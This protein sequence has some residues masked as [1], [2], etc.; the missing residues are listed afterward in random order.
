MRAPTSLITLVAFCVLLLTGQAASQKLVFAHYMV[1]TVTAAHAQQDIK[2]AAAMGL[3]GFALNIGDPT[4]PFVRDA[5]N[6]MFDFTRDKYPKFKLFFSL[7][8]WASGGAGKR[9]GDYDS[10]LR[11]FMGH[12]AY[13]KGANGFP[14]VSTFGDGGTTKDV[15]INWKKKWAN[16]VYLVP[17]FD[18]TQGY[19][20]AAPGWWS[21]WGEVVDGLFSWESSWPKVGD[22]NTADMNLDKTVANGARDRKKAYMIGLSMLQYKNAYGARLWRAG[23]DLLTQRM[24]NILNMNP[25]PEYVEILTWN[26]GPEG[27]YIGNLWPEQNG[28]A[29]PAAYANSRA[30]HWSIQ[31]LLASFIRAYKA[32]QGPAA[33][34]PPSL[35]P[36]RP[37][38]GAIWYKP[39]NSQTNCPGGDQYAQKPLGYDAAKD[40]VAWAVVVGTGSDVAGWKVRFYSGGKLVGGTTNL[41]AGLNSGVSQAL[42]TGSQRME[43]LNKEG[44][45]VMRAAGGRCVTNNCPDKIYNLNPQVVG[46]TMGSDYPACK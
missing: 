3:D 37:V 33:M 45:V 7:D 19:Y 23:E 29:Q 24:K 6:K 14:F 36:A 46:L 9:L 16:K 5:L 27:H 38:V 13:Q 21:Y 12:G 30:Q 40:V 8:L 42:N 35:Q 25:Q 17:D 32:G 31:P 22:R 44:K 1:G 28:D 34:R 4:Q 2:D 20:D 11:D 26:D 10:L 43:V 18:Q 39:I 15:W 41:V